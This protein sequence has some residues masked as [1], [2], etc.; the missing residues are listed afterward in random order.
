M[1]DELTVYLDSK[2]VGELTEESLVVVPK[3]FWKKELTKAMSSPRPFEDKVLAMQSDAQSRS[4][5]SNLFEPRASSQF[6]MP[7]DDLLFDMVYNLVGLER[8]DRAGLDRICLGICKKDSSWIYASD[9]SS[10]TPTEFAGGD[11]SSTLWQTAWADN[12]PL[13]I[14]EGFA[15]VTEGEDNFE[16]IAKG[17]SEINGYIAHQIEVVGS[18]RHSTLASAAVSQIFD[19]R[20]GLHNYKKITFILT[21]V[22]RSTQWSVPALSAGSGF[23][24][25]GEVIIQLGTK[26]EPCFILGCGGNTG[27]NG[28]VGLDLS[29]GNPNYT[30]LK[31]NSA[32]VIAG[33][34]GGGPSFRCSSL[35][36][37]SELIV[38]GGGGASM[39]KSVD[40]S[41][42]PMLKQ[43][44]Q[45]YFSK[46]TIRRAGPPSMRVQTGL[47]KEIKDL[48][49]ISTV[50][51]LDKFHRLH[52]G[53]RV[54]ISDASGDGSGSA[55]EYY[56]KSLGPRE[57]QLYLDEA[58]TTPKSG[59]SFNIETRIILGQTPQ[60]VDYGVGNLFKLEFDTPL[61]GYSEG[62]LVLAKIENNTVKEFNQMVVIEATSLATEWLAPSLT[63]E[64]TYY[65][66][67]GIGDI[68]V[69]TSGRWSFLGREGKLESFSQS[70][71][72]YE[73]ITIN[74]NGGWFG[75][76]GDSTEV[77]KIYNTDI[78]AASKSVQAGGAP[79]NAITS[80]TVMAS[81]Y[82]LDDLT[83]LQG[84]DWVLGKAVA[85]PRVG[86]EEDAKALFLVED[87]NVEGMQEHI[88]IEEIKTEANAE[89]SLYFGGTT[90]TWDGANITITG[91]G[92]LSFSET[93]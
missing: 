18:S 54:F 6:R 16:L 58:L 48:N 81:G 87:Y 55:V 15:V 60:S 36:N 84:E 44:N 74:G 30:I 93:T 26:E 31:G 66:S 38:V 5:G 46:K 33:G 71:P 76:S 70:M 47:I 88:S 57:F 25:G 39:G 29:D 43:T 92:V 69:P 8:L 50:S 91:S 24:S 67:N 56:A 34:G 1:I 52:N 49:G 51:V 80:S 65:D 90:S 64:G 7:D 20:R 4:Y 2:E 10:P 82:D 32:S 19:Q 78:A 37:R 45:S 86:S 68:C 85:T 13:Q 27:K 72:G 62:D 79:G 41:A 14:N 42:D 28:G 40:L 12:E 11:T 83:A 35:E 23:R 75:V 73:N 63:G 59:M 22:F 61:Q 89:L 3:Q 17:A 9:V 77:A 53:D 21:G